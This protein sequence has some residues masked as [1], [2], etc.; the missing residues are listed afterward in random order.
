MA[1]EIRYSSN[2]SLTNGTLNDTYSTSGLTANQTTAGLLR[3]VKDVAI[4]WTGELLDK[5]SLVTPRLAMFS[6][7]DSVN[8]IEIGVQISGNFRAFMRLEAGHQ[9]GPLWLGTTD[10][11]ARANTAPVK[12]FYVMYEQ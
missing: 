5:G 10:V 9:A 7:L 1:N 2:M 12:L 4:T 11:W 8:F 6:N 3:N